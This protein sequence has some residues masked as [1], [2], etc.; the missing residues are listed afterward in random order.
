MKKTGLIALFIAVVV[1]ASSLY[2]LTRNGEKEKVQ[3]E[4]EI[5]YLT[6]K[7]IDE[8]ISE[9][10][11]VNTSGFF[12]F[13]KKNG[14]WVNVFTEYVK[15]SGN[16]IYAIESILKETLAVDEIEKDVLSLGK[17]GLDKPAST[18]KYVTASGNTGFLKIGNS[19]VGEKYY[20]T[21]DD[22]NVYTMDVSEAGLFF[23]GMRAFADMTLINVDI[24][25][26]LNVTISK[27][28]EDIVISKKNEAEL[29]EENADALFTYGLT[30]PVKENAS[31]ND[32]QYLFE[33]IAN[34]AAAEYDP[35]ADDEACGF[36]ESDAYFA[37]ETKNGSAKFI[38][39]NKA[40]EGYTYIKVDGVKGA[41]KISDEEISFMDYTAFD[42]VDK[43]IA[44]YYYD[45]ISKIT[46]ET[47]NEKYE[48]I[49][50]ESPSCN[51]NSIELDAFQ[52]FYRSL[53][54]LSY[55]GNVETETEAVKGAVTITFE[56][57]GGK[58]VT[59]YVNYDAM[60]YAVSRNG[61]MEFTIQKKFVE[62]I[63]TLVKEL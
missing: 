34:T 40:E 55:E 17:Y 18:V 41:Y 31:P 44:L 12:G 29:M 33:A 60:N 28:G 15:T 5:T 57:A 37:Y 38:L 58:D 16:T 14:E 32:V 62:K 25:E 9:I 21:V 26:F 30:S 7:T 35:Y 53:I 2:L 46:I 4:S 45:E 50:G 27:A 24:A 10:S 61:A 8:D 49:A 22:K 3:E 54:S 36:T 56:T 52:E 1:L 39:G 51:G 23:V 13:E 43:H 11:L 20:F 63:L 59:E 47:A 48:L 42:V 6:V 19:I